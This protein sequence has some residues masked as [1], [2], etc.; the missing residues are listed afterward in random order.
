MSAT[1]RT[2]VLLAAALGISLGTT[3]AYQWLHPPKLAV[4]PPR[5]GILGVRSNVANSELQNSALGPNLANDVYTKLSEH[6]SALDTAEAKIATLTN[7]AE[8]LASGSTTG[9]PVSLLNVSGTKAYTLADGTYPGQIKRVEC[10]TAASTPAGTLT[11]TTPLGSE[12]TSYFFDTANQAVVFSW[13]AA[14]S[15]PTTYGWHV[16]GKQRAGKKTFTV[17]TNNVAAAELHLQVDLSI[18]NTVTSTLGD[19]QVP[20]EEMHITVSTAGGT[21]VGSLTTTH[22]TGKAGATASTGLTSIGATTAYMWM[23][24]D[25]ANW[26]EIASTGITIS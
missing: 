18:T 13:Q 26:H 6:D 25:G 16:I 23:R 10:I 12:P 22:I 7:G 14:S 1:K 17:G 8:I 9:A 19:G 21:P 2:L 4:P 24:W 5:A 20:G 15:A 3:A 11:V